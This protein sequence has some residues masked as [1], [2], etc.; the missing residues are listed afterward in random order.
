[1]GYGEKALPK[2]FP[3][4]LKRVALSPVVPKSWAKM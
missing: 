1:V 2:S 4:E 3:S